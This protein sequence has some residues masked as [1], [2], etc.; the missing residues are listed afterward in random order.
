MKLAI[1]KNYLTTGFGIL[2]GL[3][4]LVSQTLA[5][6]ASMGY[7]NLALSQ[8]VTHWMLVLTAIG[9][10]GLGIV[11]KAFNVHSTPDQVAASGATVA[12][13]PNAPALVVAADKAASK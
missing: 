6:L 12:G 9:L 2:A 11:S 7:P 3:P 5:A 4:L 13:D 10:I 1:W 8:T